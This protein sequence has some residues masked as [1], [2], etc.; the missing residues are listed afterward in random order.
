MSST[1]GKYE[2]EAANPILGAVTKRDKRIVAYD[3]EITDHNDDGSAD[4]YQ[5]TV[6]GRL[7][8]RLSEFQ[9]ARLG[10]LPNLPQV[11]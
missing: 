1:Y 3:V 4:E 6:N 5:I 9:A 7:I 11:R 8:K 10:I 2:T